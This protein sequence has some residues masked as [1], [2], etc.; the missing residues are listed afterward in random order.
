MGKAHNELA[1][2]TL[3]FTRRAI[4]LSCKIE[5]GLNL[6]HKFVVEAFDVDANII[7][8]SMTTD[9]RMTEVSGKKDGTAKVD[10]FVQFTKR[11]KGVPISGMTQESIRGCGSG[12]FAHYLDKL[13]FDIHNAN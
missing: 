5:T 12:E 9:T 3:S 7:N 6:V 11:G 2:N 1:G 8:N 10:N 4:T 13:F